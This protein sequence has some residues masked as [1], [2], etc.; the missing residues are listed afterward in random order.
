MLLLP[1]ACFWKGKCAENWDN[2]NFHFQHVTKCKNRYCFVLLKKKKE[3]K[4]DLSQVPVAHAC[5]SNY[6]GGLQLEA[7]MG[8]KLAKPLLKGKKLG[9]VVSAYQPSYSRRH[10]IEGSQSS[11][12]WT[13]SETYLQNKLSKKGWRHGSR[14]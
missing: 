14:D 6:L 12:A 4:K 8:K 13:K 3:R 11:L 10:K 7:R 5:N 9:V 2:I 1:L